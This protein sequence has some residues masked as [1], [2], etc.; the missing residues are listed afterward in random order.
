MSNPFLSP[1]S[2]II[3]I[4][5]EI[6]NNFIKYSCLTSR[7][8][9]RMKQSPPIP[10]SAPVRSSRFPLATA[11][12]NNLSAVLSPSHSLMTSHISKKLELLVWFEICELGSSGE[13]L[14]CTVSHGDNL[15]CRGVFILHQG[16]QRRIRVTIVHETDEEVK[17]RDVREVLVGMLFKLSTLIV[18]IGCALYFISGH[19]FYFQQITLL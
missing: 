12:M 15:P 1:H 4:K 9:R 11:P 13:Y 10:I 14:P 18:G 3:I 5:N 8:P 6:H 16:I 2:I 19:I 17:W 7:T